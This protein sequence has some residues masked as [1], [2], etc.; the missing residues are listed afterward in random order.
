MCVCVCESKVRM[1]SDWSRHLT[2]REAM[3]GEKLEKLFSD[4]ENDITATFND[5]QDRSE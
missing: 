1:H 4:V 2:S 5:D 3:N